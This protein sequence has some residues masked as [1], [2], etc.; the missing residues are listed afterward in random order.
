MTAD[1]WR[2]Y[3]RLFKRGFHS[4]KKRNNIH[5]GSEVD[6]LN[7]WGRHLRELPFFEGL[8]EHELA[9]ILQ[10]SRLRTLKDKEILF[11]EGD[12]RTHVYVLGKGTILISKLTET[13][14]ESL[15]NVLGEGEIFPHTGFFDQAPYPG[16]AKAKKDV[17]VLAI[18]IE[19][20]EMLIK[21]HPE[22]AFRMIQVMNEK[23]VFLQK[24]LNEVLSL[25]VEARLMGALAHLQETQ[26]NTIF[27]THQE[28]GN[29]IGST[30]ETVSRQLKKWE[31]NNWVE[32]KKD[33]IILIKDFND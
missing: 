2:V 10:I 19:R 22:L 17:K 31:K 24:K 20:F 30:R 6:V 29:I 8:T 32:V 7:N 15:I 23:I 13:G 11:M 21:N 4:G 16:T 12:K 26:G 1:I 9:P 5:S 18:P 3:Q 25:N 27:L 28:I 33:R 14:E